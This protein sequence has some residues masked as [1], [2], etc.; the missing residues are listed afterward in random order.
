MIYLIDELEEEIQVSTHD[1]LE[2]IRNGIDWQDI[3]EGKTKI[4]DEDGMMYKWDSSKENEIG[5]VF[6]YT[7]IP[8]N[9]KYLGFQEILKESVRAENQFDF[10]FKKK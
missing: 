8:V 7:L 3:F 6:G 2:A 4:V 9:Q 5:T 10:A 1:S